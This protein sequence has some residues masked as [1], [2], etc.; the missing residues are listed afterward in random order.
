MP[1]DDIRYRISI[2][3]HFIGG[4]VLFIF[5]WLYKVCVAG[6]KFGNNADFLVLLFFHIPLFYL[7]ALVILPRVFKYNR[8]VIYRALY[9]LLLET[10]VLLLVMTGL[11]LIFGG[12]TIDVDLSKSWVID[13]GNSLLMIFPYIFS[14][15]LSVAYYAVLFYAQG[16]F[17][18][19]SENADLEESIHIYK[20]AWR[21][22]QLNPHLLGNLMSAL[23]HI[24]IH[25]PKKAPKAMGIVI[26]IMRYYVENSPR[27]YI[28][29]V[30][31]MDQVKNLI[32][33]NELRFER[34]SEIQFDIKCEME[35]VMIIPM[36]LVPLV[37]NIFN[38]AVLGDSNYPAKIHGSLLPGS[39]YFYT[40]NWVMT[41]KPNE[42]T[43][44]GLTNLQDRLNY[45]Y[46]D[47]HSFEYGMVGRK[48]TTVIL[49]W[50]K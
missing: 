45:F 32:S 11:S 31:E 4:I 33:L 25:T 39:Y 9:C 24:T 50:D 17:Q 49:L 18:S 8:L 12:L 36:L 6:D 16:Y 47:R 21:K 20:Q 10:I 13:I 42:S 34:N 30:E 14:L 44:S 1:D 28:P 2:K 3:W 48:F 23:R 46:P 15:I 38:Y 35:E 43:G 7:N 41:K 26:E 5:Y 29:L 40:E 37:E 22:A 19:K 27:P